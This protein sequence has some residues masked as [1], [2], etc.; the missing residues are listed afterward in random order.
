MPSAA[1]RRGHDPA[2]PAGA[3]HAEALAGELDA[4]RRLEPAGADVAVHAHDAAAGGQ[5][6]RER[7]L[8]DALITVAAI[9]A[10]PDA[11]A[12]GGAEVDVAGRARAEKDDALQARAR[13]EQ[14]PVHHGVIVQGERAAFEQPDRLVGRRA[15]DV[16]REIRH[17]LGD[18]AA[19]K[20][21]AGTADNR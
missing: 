5:H 16:D 13:L 12:L 10:H 21:R 1:P 4:V 9:G 11:E 6:Q 7:V 19:G 20:A 14:R 3:D 2:D 8:G 15:A 17:D 18:L